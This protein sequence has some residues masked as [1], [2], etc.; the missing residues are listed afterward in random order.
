[1][2]AALLPIPGLSLM[3][4]LGLRHGFDPD[5]I[6][7]IDS[8]AY[9]ALGERPR[10]APWTGTLFALGHG[11]AVTAI[12]VALGAFSSG[13][14]LPALLRTILDWLPTLLLILVGTLN[15]RDLLRQQVYRPRGWK[16]FFMPRRLRNSPSSHPLAIFGTGVLFALVFDTATQAAAWGYAATANAGSTA[17]LVAGLAFTAG[18]VVTDSADGRLMVRLLRGTSDQAAATAAAYRRRIGWTV[19]LM[20]YGM[21]LYQIAAALR[22]DIELDDFAFTFV[23]GALVASLLIACGVLVRKRAAVAGNRSA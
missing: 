16:T 8:M 9:R 11:L 18:M 13:I 19:V 3:F 20:S 2:E 5:H 17:A 6:A 10:L 21:A 15:L 23:G 7:I 22:P 4:M 1:M 12:A 14:A